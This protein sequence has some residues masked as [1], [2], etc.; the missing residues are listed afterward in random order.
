MGSFSVDID[1]RRF[2]TTLTEYAAWKEAWW[3]EV[4]Q[5]GVDAGAT[6]CAGNVSPRG[7]VVVVSFEDDGRGMDLDTLTKVF[8]R[9]GR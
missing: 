8:L 4:V 3:R 1:P 9:L 2:Q 7:D 5:N 6:H